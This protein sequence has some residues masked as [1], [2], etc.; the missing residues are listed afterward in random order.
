VA[1]DPRD[2]LHSNHPLGRDTPCPVPVLDRLV[3]DANV[4]GDLFEA[5]AFDEV[6]E[7][8]HVASLQVVPVKKQVTKIE[9]TGFTC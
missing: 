5:V 1:T 2:P 6:L 4:G 3:P 8:V 9:L 7:C